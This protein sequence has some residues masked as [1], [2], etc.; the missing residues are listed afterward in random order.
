MNA[1]EG[2]EKYSG[3]TIVATNNNHE[4]E[5]LRTD[6]NNFLFNAYKYN[7]GSGF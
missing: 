6:F 7:S 4:Y 1:K 3:Y 2:I 5:N